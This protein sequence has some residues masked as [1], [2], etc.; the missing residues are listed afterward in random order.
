LTFL[1]NNADSLIAVSKGYLKWGLDKIGRPERSFDKVFYL[2]YKNS[3]ARNLVNE[4]ESSDLPDWLKGREEQKIFLFIGTFG[5]SYELELILDA[6]EHFQKT[7]KSN[8]CFVLAGTGDKSDLINKKAAGLQNV[9]LPGWIGQKEINRLLKKGYA[10]LLSYVKDAPQ[11]LPNKSFEYLS[12]GLPLINSLEGEMAELVKQ[13]R[14]GLNYLPGDLEGLCQ[15]IERLTADRKLYD[16]MSKNAL[17][18]YQ[19]YGDAEKIYDE[20]AE[21]IEKVTEHYRY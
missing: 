14:L 2:G 21:F 11:G 20:Y 7:K 12:V 13:H 1:L 17:D 5:I 6:A 10:G 19:K 8:I 9:V 15:S 4:D 18:F 16:K 3:N